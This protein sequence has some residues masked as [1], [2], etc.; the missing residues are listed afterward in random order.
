MTN[1][2]EPCMS[3]WMSQ[4]GKDAVWGAGEKDRLCKFVKK[5]GSRWREHCLNK[6]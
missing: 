1:I 3:L 6:S 4:T 2:S 5:E